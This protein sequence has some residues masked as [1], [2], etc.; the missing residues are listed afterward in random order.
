MNKINF[1]LMALLAIGTSYAQNI[2]DAVRYSI[3]N[4]S[5][6]A[7]YQGVSGAFGALGGDLS[8]INNNPASSAIF[9]NSYAS[10]TAALDMYDNSTQYFNGSTSTDDSD[11]NFNQGGG[12]FVLDNNDESSAFRKLAIAF[13][14]DRTANFD[15]VYTA[16]GIGNTSIDSYFLQ[17]AQ[18]TPLDLLQYRSGENV[19]DL[20]DYL[21][22]NEGFGAQQAFLGYQGYIVDPAEDDPDNTSYSSAIGSGNFDQEYTSLTSGYA[23]KASFNIA[24]QYKEKLYVGLNLN[25]HFIDYRQSTILFEDNAN[26]N[27][28]VTNLRFENNL[29]TL[30]NG[31]SFQIGGIYHLSPSLRVGL[32]YDSPTWYNIEEETTQRLTT[33]GVNGNVTLDPRVTNVYDDYTLQTPGKG[34]AGLAYIFGSNGFLSFDYSYE[35]FSSVTFKPKNDTFFQGLNDEIDSNLKAVSTYKVGGEIKVRKWSFRGGYKYQ[36]SPYEND[37]IMSNLSGFSA[38][39]GYSFGSARLDLAYSRY[40]QESNPQ[41]YDTGLTSTAF[42]DGVNSTVA[43]TFSFR[44]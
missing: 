24:T 13:N 26:A 39:L 43:A 19:D 28:Q 10:I 4:I 15:N 18:G 6:T 14:Y 42:I 12:V 17:F 7:R 25:S 9:T 30:G 3:Q 41:L 22:E 38:G 31:F 23:G 40:T 21:G 16:S 34:T 27:S 32:T 36:E 37:D 29:S 20:Y 5:G 2:N 35:D 44:L 8:A 11:I 33:S 1:L